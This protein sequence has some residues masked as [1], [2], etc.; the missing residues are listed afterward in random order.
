MP[1]TIRLEDDGIYR[2][3]TG[4]VSGEEILASNCHLHSL[5]EFRHIGYVINDFSAMDDHAIEFAHTSAYATSDQVISNTKDRLKIA[6]VVTPQAEHIALA[7]HYQ[8]M[9]L[10]CHFECGIF[11]SPEQA[12]VWARQ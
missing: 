7:Q 2:S 6:L 12:Y 8:E 5:P 1:H 11:H 10:G 9:M 4:T 3:F